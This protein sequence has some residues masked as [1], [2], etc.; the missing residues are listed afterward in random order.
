[1]A[2][3]TDMNKGGWELGGSIYTKDFGDTP[4]LDGG[5]DLQGFL[6]WTAISQYTRGK[7]FQ[8]KKFWFYWYTVEVG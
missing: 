4:Q 2:S 3:N 8:P 5:V 6:S 7:T 1:M